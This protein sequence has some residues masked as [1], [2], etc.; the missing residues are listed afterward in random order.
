MRQTLYH[1][2]APCFGLIGENLSRSAAYRLARKWECQNNFGR[3]VATI[4]KC[5]C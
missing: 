1:V 4:Q 2:F 3:G 5:K